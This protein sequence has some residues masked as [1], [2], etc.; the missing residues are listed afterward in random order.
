M[1]LPEPQSSQTIAPFTLPPWTT[2]TLAGGIR[3]H[4]IPDTT[5]ELLTISF[6]CARGAT[7]QTRASQAVMTGAMLTRGTHTHTAPQIADIIDAVGAS[8]R[9]SGTRD[10]VSLSVSGLAKHT[11]IMLRVAV[12]CILH[13]VFDAEEFERLRS[14]YLSDHELSLAYPGYCASQAF[15]AMMYK[16]HPYGNALNG[17]REDLLSI[18]PEDCKA[19]Y[20]EMRERSAWTVVV[21]GACNTE[22]ILRRLEEALT[23]LRPLPAAR[24]VYTAS[25]S[26]HITT[27]YT[28]VESA[29]QAVFQ[30]GH[31]CIGRLDP[32]YAALTV[33]NTLFG[34]YFLSRLNSVLRE[35]KGYTYGVN[36]SLSFRRHG[37]M[38]LAWSSV[39][40][41]NLEESLHIVH[42]EWR[43][44]R[45]EP[46][47][48]A[49]FL[50][51]RRYLS[52]I[53]AT[54]IE[55]PQQVAQYIL[56]ADEYGIDP[57]EHEAMARRIA[58]MPLHELHE[59]QHRV[60][61]P[62]SLVVVAAGKEQEIIAP[63]EA[64]AAATNATRVAPEPPEHYI[65]R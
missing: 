45:D 1:P 6:V 41:E 39:R 23:E 38:F 26:A 29:H 24:A 54:S 12:D 14:L 4:C 28:C 53:L 5:Q 43:R 59:A 37:S 35:E 11:D 65:V 32:D 30:V 58:N 9:A 57:H 31:H 56:S 20:T 3:V 21:A 47:P 22:N 17:T 27:A 52:G 44:L 40:S 34:E 48:E 55:T 61:L 13:P 18:T 60:I 51:C 46:I 49:E 63:L 2:S 15:G 33:L 10:T 42:K 50:L 64:F 36:S 8:I 7:E 62:D 19:F 16:H 25:N